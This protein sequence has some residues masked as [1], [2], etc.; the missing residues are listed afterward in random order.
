MLRAEA[1]TARAELKA[2]SA[3]PAAAVR[4]QSGKTRLAKNIN[5]IKGVIL[6][7]P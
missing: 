6:T 4:A 5:E 2:W 1:A 3:A 7:H